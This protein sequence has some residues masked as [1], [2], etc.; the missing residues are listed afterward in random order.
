M[1]GKT[2]KREERE[3][4]RLSFLPAAEIIIQCDHNEKNQITVENYGIGLEVHEMIKMD[5]KRL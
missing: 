1:E 3:R 4:L 2:R 5:N